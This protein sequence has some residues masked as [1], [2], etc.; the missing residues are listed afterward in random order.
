MTGL[1]K[2]CL[3]CSGVVLNRLTVESEQSSPSIQSRRAL[4]FPGVSEIHPW[5]N[6]LAGQSPLF[7]QPTCPIVCVGAENTSVCG[8]SD[9]VRQQFDSGCHHTQCKIR[10][11]G[12]HLCSIYLTD[13]ERLFLSHKIYNTG[14]EP[15]LEARMVQTF[16]LNLTTF[17]LSSLRN[18]KCMI[19][20]NSPA[21]SWKL[22]KKCQY[23]CLPQTLIVSLFQEATLKHHYL[24][25][26]T[27]DGISPVSPYRDTIKNLLNHY[28]NFFIFI[29]P[30]Y[31]LKVIGHG[32][33]Y[34][35][36][37]PELGGKEQGIMV[38]EP[39]ET[40]A[41]QS[42]SGAESLASPPLSSFCFKNR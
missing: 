29:S 5:V 10:P 42:S 20:F 21:R 15:Y 6:K 30:H 17:S 14:P 12:Q 2:S 7:S 1:P 9:P 19:T 37:I 33:N 36:M 16:S 31:A 11:F 3:C 40:W 28:F 18:F 4:E 27:S 13:A 34:R 38:S 25:K 23:L 8:T 24:P 41:H 32:L 39:V 35:V 26:E 22:H